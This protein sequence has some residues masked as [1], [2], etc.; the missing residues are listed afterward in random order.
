MR[1]R[2][3]E[4]RPR[5]PQIDASGM[6]ARWLASRAESPRGISTTRFARQVR[7]TRPRRPSRQILKAMGRQRRRDAGAPEDEDQIRP[8]PERG[9]CRHAR[10]VERLALRRDP[11]LGF[12]TD[13]DLARPG[14]GAAYRERRKK[15]RRRLQPRA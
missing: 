7:R 13:L 9:A 10:R 11:A 6:P 12:G 14:Y 8:S 1:T 5:P 4:H 2:Q 3:V 15:Q